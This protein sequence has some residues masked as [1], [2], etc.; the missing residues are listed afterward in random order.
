MNNRIDTA[1]RLLRLAS[2]R[3]RG[4]KLK[5]ITNKKNVR[6][7]VWVRETAKDTPRLTRAKER[8]QH[9]LAF[10]RPQYA[11]RDVIEKATPSREGEGMG[12]AI[13]EGAISDGY[14]ILAPYVKDEA[15][16]EQ[17]RDRLDDLS[18]DL[19]PLGE[20]KKELDERISMSRDKISITLGDDFNLSERMGIDWKRGYR[21]LNNDTL[22]KKAKEGLSI[23]GEMIKDPV[24]SHLQYEHDRLVRVIDALEGYMNDF[25][26]VEGDRQVLLKEVDS[27]YEEA[28]PLIDHEGLMN[29]I[30][31]QS[32]LSEEEASRA[33]S[34]IEMPSQE[35]TGYP[36]ETIRDWTK[37]G[38]L[39]M[40]KKIKIYSMDGGL[41]TICHYSGEI[42][43]P[44]LKSASADD[45]ESKASVFHEMAHN[46]EYENFKVVKMNAEWVQSRSPEA[47]FDPYV[48]RLYQTKREGVTS[49]EVV[50]TGV[51]M[52]IS[53]KNAAEL[54]VR[55]PEHMAIT[56]KAL[57]M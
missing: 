47:S 39:L 49:T 9:A 52:L 17:L 44:K 42:S 15:K 22:L 33:V 50:S 34:S 10:R 45:E 21:E 18:K 2:P 5:E 30:R 37:E 51:E 41:S 12:R 36:I 43:L 27:I 54:L 57:M 26:K 29:E 3:Q 4:L 16:M 53:H 14:K 19:H 40:G 55:D 35:T 11:P 20:K 6:Q 1:R 56:L 8:L 24:N 31:S 7:K 48:N 23:T 32:G 38:L 25:A 46:I 28:M 13:V